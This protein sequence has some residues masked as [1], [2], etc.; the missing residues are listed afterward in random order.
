[1]P[2]VAAGIPRT[3]VRARAAIGIAVSTEGTAG[4]FTAWLSTVFGGHH[5]LEI[6]RPRTTDVIEWLGERA[7]S[8]DNMCERDQARR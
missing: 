1:M 6:A 2:I 7:A 8:N 5:Q 4:V 3:L